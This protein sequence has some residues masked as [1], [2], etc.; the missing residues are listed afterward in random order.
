MRRGVTESA[1]T[2]KD[3]PNSVASLMKEA[4]NGDAS[5]LSALKERLPEEIDTF[6]L[7]E[8]GELG[9]TAENALVKAVAG[10]NL[11]HVEGLKLKAERLK[12]DLAGPDP[13]PLE[14]LLVERIV[15]CWI[16]ATY[17]DAM[18][19]QGMAG[20]SWAADECLQRRQA[21][22]LRAFGFWIRYL[23]FSGVVGVFAL[24]RRGKDAERKE[25]I[26]R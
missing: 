14:R 22:V 17:A 21:R 24:R 15:C 18:Y 4:E 2:D 16:L 20:R 10:G 26:K 7:E 25:A 23:L 12:A 5:A 3:G 6:L 9:Q 19:A 1:A 13:S 8:Y 11:L